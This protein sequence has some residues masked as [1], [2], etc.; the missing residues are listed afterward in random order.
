V[1]NDISCLLF[2]GFLPVVF[3]TKKQK[4][5]QPRGLLFVFLLSLNRTLIAA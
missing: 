1:L 4:D 2:F 3:W 5:E